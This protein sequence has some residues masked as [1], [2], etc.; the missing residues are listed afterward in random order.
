MG[1]TRSLRQGRQLVDLA[2][3]R[4]FNNCSSDLIMIYSSHFFILL[5]GHELPPC[6]FDYDRAGQYEISQNFITSI[7]DQLNVDSINEKVQI[8]SY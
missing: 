7:G 8:R 5:Y 6:R 3:F 1:T 2:G 4:D